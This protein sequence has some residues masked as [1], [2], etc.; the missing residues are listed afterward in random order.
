[1]TDK[2]LII[3]LFHK[4]VKGKKPNIQG[5]NAK[6][7]GR[8]GH[9][10]EAQFGVSHNASNAPDLFGYEL[11]NETSSKTTFGDWSANYYIYNDIKYLSVFNSNITLER[12]DKFL[13]IFGKPNEK[14]NNRYS[15]SG[16]PAPKIDIFNK[17][18][19]RLIID[20]NN[21]II[22][23]YSYSEDT[24]ENKDK[25]VP[26][27]L[28]KENLVIAIWYGNSMPQGITGKSLKE[29]VESKFNDKGWFTCKMNNDG[30]YDKICFG[31]SITFDKW[32]GL[33]KQGIVYF[34]SGMHQVNPRP[35]SEWRAD[36]KYWDSLI[37]EVFD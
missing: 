37:I 35:Y 2:E 22:A 6:H 29:K 3:D 20:E 33:V 19:Q 34:D 16:E 31:T 4:N 9:W 32:I 36:N 18:G 28:Q 12:R 8:K 7:D 25:I 10:L 13:S 26:E 11:K 5:A 30:V 21:N 24:R 14:K 27:I 17:F 15:W 23:E 1:M